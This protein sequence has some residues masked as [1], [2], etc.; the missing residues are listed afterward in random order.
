MLLDIYVAVVDVGAELDGLAVGAVEK[1]VLL[2]NRE[3]LADGNLRYVEQRREL[4]NAHLAL[5]LEL[6]GDEFVTFVDVHLD[7]FFVLVVKV[8]KKA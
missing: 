7:G 4:R 3:I 2:E 8:R 5:G 1:V 6:A